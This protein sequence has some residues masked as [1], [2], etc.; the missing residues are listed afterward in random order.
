[1]A[2]PRRRQASLKTIR[3]NV[4]HLRKMISRVESFALTAPPAGKEFKIRRQGSRLIV[5]GKV[6]K[7]ADLDKLAGTQVEW[8]LAAA[9]WL[10]QELEKEE[11][12]RIK[13]TKK[14]H[15]VTQLDDLGVSHAIAG[16]DQLND[17]ELILFHEWLNDNSQGTDGEN[18]NE[19]YHEFG[20]REVTK[21][22][23]LEF[24]RSKGYK[25]VKDMIYYQGIEGLS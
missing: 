10:E 25:S 5:N 4:S 11:Y 16:L 19:F 20:A 8:Q 2:K 1:M 3:E 12:R 18:K 9:S 6:F 13:M 17:E 23:V 15:K 7:P 22:T 21:A 24:I 14:R